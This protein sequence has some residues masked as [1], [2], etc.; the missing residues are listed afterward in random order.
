MIRAGY[1]LLLFS[2]TATMLLWLF[3]V[4]KWFQIR[5]GISDILWV[6]A[7]LSR[8]EEAFIQMSP[9]S[10]TV[11]NSTATPEPEVCVYEEPPAEVLC[12]KTV[13]GDVSCEV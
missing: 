13:S 9:P 2:A 10:W 7:N 1:Y 8:D 5:I 12:A 3:L 11:D 4:A 6:R